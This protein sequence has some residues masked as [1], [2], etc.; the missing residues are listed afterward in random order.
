MSDKSQIP[1][2][3]ETESGD[4]A[5]IP[6]ST[7]AKRNKKYWYNRLPRWVYPMALGTA[8]VSTVGLVEMETSVIQSAVFN[9]AAQG[10]LFTS[11][12]TINDKTAPMAQGHYD[13]R[14]GYSRTLDIRK[15]ITD[16]GY[17]IDG[18]TTWQDRSVFGI[19]LFPI[20]DE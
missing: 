11:N 5:A 1:Q 2:E 13:V 15:R 17:Q 12:K 6:D 8:A 4:I 16:R 20:Y 3:P 9:A 14:H 10:N 18:T 19:G 7:S